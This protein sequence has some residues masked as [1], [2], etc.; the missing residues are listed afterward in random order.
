MLDNPVL[1]GFCQVRCFRLS[2]RYGVTSVSWVV[3]VWQGYGDW[4]LLRF[5]ALLWLIRWSE[6][7]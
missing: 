1:S 6:I 7:G 3:S 4:G 2:A 5:V